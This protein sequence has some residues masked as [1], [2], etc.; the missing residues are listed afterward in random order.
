MFNFGLLALAISAFGIGTTEF[1]IMGLLPNV[2]QDLGVT[3]PMAGML[4][5]AYALAVAIGAPVMAVLTSR[6]PRKNALL[7]LMGIF[8]LGN[9]MCA[10]SPNYHVLIIARIITAL[11]HGAFFGIGSVEAAALAPVNRKASAVAMMFTGLTLANVLGVPLGTALGQAE[12][13][14]MTFWVVTVIGVIALASLAKLLPPDHSGDVGDIRKELSALKD[15]KVWLALLMTVLASGSMF[16]L[17]TYIAPILSELTHVSPRGISATLLL[18]GVGLTVGNFIGGRLA[19]W[20][21]PTA[22]IGNTVVIILL[23]LIFY[24]T[25]SI[26]IPAEVT[27]FLWGAAAFAACSALQL[28]AMTRGSKAPN[29]I[30]TLN[31]GAFN[32]GNALGA[33]VGGMVIEKGFGLRPVTLSGS[34]L[35][36]IGLVVT[37]IALYG[38]R[39]AK[40]KI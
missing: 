22:L 36:A 1:V 13:W 21:L 34:M 39:K 20:S 2:A 28:N 30:A 6:L 18:L 35:A 23:Q 37:L 31:I 32:T 26:L 3:I 24:W 11:C 8:I 38:V 17:F 12:G 7:I 14:R 33:F 40:A 27:L 25:S 4:I 29:L 16:T 10:L 15:G 5:T 19:D 9:A